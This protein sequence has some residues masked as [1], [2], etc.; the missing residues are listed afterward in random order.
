MSLREIKQRIGSVKTTQKITSA[1]KLVSSAKLHRAQSAVE[2]VRPYQRKLDSIFSAFISGLS[3]GNAYTEKRSLERVAIVAVASNST[4]CGAFNSNIIK[5]MRSVADEYTTRGIAV[6]LY[7]VGKKMA[8]AAKK[9]GAVTDDSLIAQAGSP[10]YTAVA[11]TAYSL[12]ERFRAKELDRIEL[13]YTSYVS[14]SRQQ[15][16]REL[17]LP[18][19]AGTSQNGP[20]SMP[21]DYIVEPGIPQV[22]KALLPK[23]IALRLYTALLDSATAEHAARMIA[24]QVATENAT[25][26]ISELT[27]E[28]NKGR[29]QAITSE[30]QD[31]LSGSI[32]E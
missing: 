4:M 28:Y 14:A 5:L 18:F 8:E 3:G 11:D 27:L 2:G 6:E 17:F 13:V 23:V 32:G 15:P 25:D 9:M 22:I 19:V 20:A 16:V 30:L 12:M 26:L 24:M 1:M 10:Q 21:V 31:I 29:Q 7:V